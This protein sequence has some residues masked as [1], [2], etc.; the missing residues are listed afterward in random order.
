MHIFVSSLP[1]FSN[2]SGIKWN[3][4]TNSERVTN[5]PSGAKNIGV[6]TVRS[7]TG[8]ESF[9]SI[10]P[11]VPNS[12]N[13]FSLYTTLELLSNLDRPFIDTSNATYDCAWYIKKD[14]TGNIYVR[15]YFN[16]KQIM[17]QSIDIA[18]TPVLFV[19]FYD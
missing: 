6:L 9:R 4:A 16:A 18:E 13:G 7:S 11:V 14:T 5:I 8:I 10:R 3:P 1:H 2:A 12:E 15:G 17:N 19:L